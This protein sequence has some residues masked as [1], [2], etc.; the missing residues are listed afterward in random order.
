MTTPNAPKRHR[1]LV[2]SPLALRALATAV[3]LSTFTGMSAFAATHLLNAAAPLQPGAAATTLVGGGDDD[4]DEDKRPVPTV[5][6][7]RRTTIGPGVT[8]TTAPA[9]T[10]TRS[11]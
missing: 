8:A 9:R 11:S 7:A 1:P 10:R 3:A 5:A 6:P 4:D 2:A